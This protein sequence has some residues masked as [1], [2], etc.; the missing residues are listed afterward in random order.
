MLEFEPPPT[1]TF[2]SFFSCDPADGGVEISWEILSDDVVKGFNIYRS[3]GGSARHIVNTNGVIPADATRFLDTSVKPGETYEYAL[4]VVLAG[5]NE[6]LSQPKTV[7]IGAFALS[8]DQN[9]PNPFNPVT[10]ISFV[11]PSSGHVSLAVYNADGALV[12]TLVDETLS[13]GQKTYSWNGR[14][15]NDN[16]VSSGVYFCRIQTGNRVL[17]QKMTLIK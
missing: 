9:Y 16:P 3:M 5:G 17:S 7:T 2:V 12:R 8:L 1:P 10:T 11:L 15:D 14:D 6:I 13:Q 4:A